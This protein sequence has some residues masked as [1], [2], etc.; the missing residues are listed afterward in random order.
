MLGL[1]H[2]RGE[3][4]GG[5]AVGERTTR[6]TSA[7]GGLFCSR[8][9]VSGHRDERI[10]QGDAELVEHWQQ[11]IEIDRLQRAFRYQPV[12]RSSTD[13]YA[14]RSEAPPQ[15]GHANTLLAH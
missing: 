2:H 5:R 9:I 4:A 7:L 8:Q 15:L 13:G 10:A 3:L 14:A 6:G 1:I 11:Q 12:E